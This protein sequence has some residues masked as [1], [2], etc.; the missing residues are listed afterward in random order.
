MS[1]VQFIG[2]DGDVIVE[3]SRSTAPGVSESIII[4]ETPYRTYHVLHRFDGRGHTVRVFVW[5]PQPFAD[6]VADE[7]Y[8]L[9]LDAYNGEVAWPP[10]V[11]AQEGD[12][13]Q[14]CNYSDV[15]RESTAAVRPESRDEGAIVNG[16]AYSV[17]STNVFVNNSESGLVIS[18]SQLED[19]VEDS[20]LMISTQRRLE[21]QMKKASERLLNED[22]KK[23]EELK[24]NAEA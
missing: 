7:L 17:L 19:G 10:S 6:D 16:N 12:F 14:L 20:R 3:E 8:N 15:V 4:D 13:V 9:V 18:L 23:W 5:E 2:P 24:E 1:V 21:G 11:D 22:K